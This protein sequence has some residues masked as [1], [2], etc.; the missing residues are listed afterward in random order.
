MSGRAAA[1]TSAVV[2]NYNA[3]QWLTEC[4]ASLRR[5][6]VGEIVVVDNCS[7]DD[8][9]SRLESRYRDVR[10]VRLPRNRGFGAGANVGVGVGV[11]GGQAVL[12]CNPDLV[13]EPLCLARLEAVLA[14]RPDVA[15]V[16][17]RL[18]TAGGETYPSARTFPSLADSLGHAFLGSFRPDN[19]FTAR[20]KMR[21]LDRTHASDV[22]WVSGACFLARRDAFDSVGGFDE[23]YFM[24]V[25]D[26]DLCWRLRRA[27]WSVRYEPAASVTHLQ[28]LSTAR[29]PYRMIAA[30][31]RSLLR[32]AS[33]TS[34][35]ARRLVLPFVAAG[36]VIRMFI[37]W[38]DHANGSRR[39]GS[40]RAIG[41]SRTAD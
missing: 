27:G 13:L 26:V 19:R 3:G 18:L 29:H 28:G 39:A 23:A 1:S 24:Y 41:T 14:S 20:Y 21:D 4:V 33:R 7:S 11:N 36:L 12:V 37:A 32:F 15:I 8:S 2:V 25:E 22:D 6:S 38:A 31:H 17:P 34:T 40:R 16:G 5:E 30:H 9:I 10:V 35:G